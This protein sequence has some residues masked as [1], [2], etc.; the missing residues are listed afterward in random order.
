MKKI[1]KE[2]DDLFQEAGLIRDKKC[3]IGPSINDDC[4]NIATLVHHAKSRRHLILRHDLSNGFSLCANCHNKVHGGEITFDKV[5]IKNYGQ[6]Y[7]NVLN[8][9]S[10]EVCKYPDYKKRKKYLENEIYARTSNI[11]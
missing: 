4:S 11:M 10:T 5:I 6:G 7:L 8:R 1:E 3:F 9:R 2:C